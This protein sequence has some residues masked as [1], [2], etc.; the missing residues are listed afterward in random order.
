MC[1]KE[2][3]NCK[4]NITGNTGQ[5]CGRYSENCTYNITGKTGHSCG[6][7]SKNSTYKTN[8]PKTLENMKQDVPK[9]NRIIFIHPDGTEETVRDYNAR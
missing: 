6:I 7:H 5:D 8:N 3:K 2:S 1:G 9:S 4:Y